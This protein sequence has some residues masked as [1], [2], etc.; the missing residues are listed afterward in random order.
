MRLVFFFNSLSSQLLLS[1]KYSN[2]ESDIATLS[3]V[4]ADRRATAR[5]T[6]FVEPC[7][8]QIK[9]RKLMIG[10]VT[11]NGEKREMETY[12]RICDQKRRQKR[13]GSL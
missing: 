3:F 2:F 5:T 13:N 1:R 10:P 9:K 4:F 7:S 8:I 11:K 6:T 12:D